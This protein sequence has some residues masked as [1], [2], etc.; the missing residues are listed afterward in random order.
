MFQ[1]PEELFS[2]EDTALLFEEKIHR[3]RFSSIYKCTLLF[4]LLMA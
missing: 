2:N 4:S 1:T 3:G